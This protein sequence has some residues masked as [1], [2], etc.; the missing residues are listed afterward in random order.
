MAGC[1][2]LG[3]TKRPEIFGTTNTCMSEGLPSTRKV[4]DAI[5]GFLSSSQERT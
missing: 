1:T 4:L 3:V 5:L 2:T